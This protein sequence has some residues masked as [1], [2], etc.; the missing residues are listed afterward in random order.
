MLRIV[1]WAT[2]SVGRHAVAA[3]HHHPDLELVGALVYSDA[4]AGRDVG[5]ICG[6]GEIG[7]AATKDRDEI[8]AI[9]A[10][11]VLYM[12]QGEMNPM[13]AVGDICA[14]LAS[15]KNHA[16]APLCAAAPGIR[17][18]LEL[19]TIVGRRVLNGQ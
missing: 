8:I 9:D 13:G 10:D 15:G 12:P 5:E 19:P 2:A 7:L 6:V 3:V 18:F 11:C 1:Q 14:L 16:I 4:K 17:T